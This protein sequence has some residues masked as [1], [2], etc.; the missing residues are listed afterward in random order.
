MVFQ[1]EIMYYMYREPLQVL[2]IRVQCTHH[3]LHA[4]VKVILKFLPSMM[5]HCCNSSGSCIQDLAL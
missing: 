1:N 5:L 3:E 2:P 4:N